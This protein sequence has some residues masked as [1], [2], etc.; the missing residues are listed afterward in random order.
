[1]LKKV[2]FCRM[3]LLR[4][5]FG[6]HDTTDTNTKILTCVYQRVESACFIIK[7]VRSHGASGRIVQPNNQSILMAL[8]DKSHTEL[9]Q[10]TVK[11]MISVADIC[12]EAMC[13]I[14]V[15]YFLESTVKA[16]VNCTRWIHFRYSGGGKYYRIRLCNYSIFVSLAI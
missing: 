15:G 16:S 4:H 8:R 5:T 3:W 2:S 10:T 9:I 14:D 7:H 13:E 6:D 12:F 11:G 1:M